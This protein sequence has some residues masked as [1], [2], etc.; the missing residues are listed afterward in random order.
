[1]LLRLLF[2]LMRSIRI[3]SMK[4]SIIKTGP[5]PE[6]IKIDMDWEKAVE[7]ALKK[8]PPKGKPVNK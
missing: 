4:K 1:M 5:K 6:H 7:K 8:E 2:I 3:M